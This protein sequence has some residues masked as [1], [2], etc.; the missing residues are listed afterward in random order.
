MIN[1][2]NLCMRR[3]KE[4]FIAAVIAAILLLLLFLLL[5]TQMEVKVSVNAVNIQVTPLSKEIN[6][7]SELIEPNP[8]P[9]PIPGVFS[10][11]YKVRIVNTGGE[12]LRIRQEPSLEGAPL[13][14][15]SEGEE[16]SIKDGP[17]ISGNNV[18]WFI[19]SEEEGLRR[20]WAVQDY[21]MILDQENGE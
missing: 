12:G 8:D 9:S 4:V 13:F 11:G 10:V 5:I 19:E 14:L 17:T 16:F 3:G 2:Y 20:G 21:L 7:T 1:V 15:G 18:W 6:D